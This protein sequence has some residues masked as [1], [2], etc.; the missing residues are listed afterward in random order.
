LPTLEKKSTNIH[1]F[2]TRSTFFIHFFCP[3]KISYL[4]DNLAIKKFG[5]PVNGYYTRTRSKFITNIFNP[6]KPVTMSVLI[7]LLLYFGI[8]RET[9]TNGQTVRFNEAQ[10]NQMYTHDSYQAYLAGGGTDW[11][12]VGGLPAVSI[13]IHEEK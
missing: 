6:K 3:Q 13:I 11:L 5:L 2:S 1:C 9:P 12:H 4:V 8:V 10:N 7:A